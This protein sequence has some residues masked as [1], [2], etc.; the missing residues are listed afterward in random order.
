MS[1]WDLLVYFSVGVCYLS[2]L[3]VIGGWIKHVKDNK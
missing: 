3:V 1:G 2:A